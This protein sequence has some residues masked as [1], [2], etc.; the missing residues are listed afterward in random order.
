MDKDGHVYLE[1]SEASP[2]LWDCLLQVEKVREWYQGSVSGDNK[3]VGT[4][5]ERREGEE[6]GGKRV[7]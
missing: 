1:F 4:E 5:V 6:N 2:S 7:S 3:G